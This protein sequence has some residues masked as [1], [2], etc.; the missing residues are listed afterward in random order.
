[1]QKK[2][3]KEY[4]GMAMSSI[5]SQALRAVLTVIIIAIGIMALV[6][7]LTSL[8]AL[9][10][11]ISGQFTQLGA[12]TF[13]IQNRGPNVTINKKG[14]RGKTF[15]YIQ[16]NEAV[17]FVERFKYEDAKVSLSYIAT[18]MAELKVG[19]EKTNPNVQI[20]ASD[21]NYLTTGG[22]ILKEGRNFS[23]SEI[24]L[25]SPVM[26]IGSDLTYLFGKENPLNKVITARGLR[27]RVIGILAS[28]GNAVGFGGDKVGLIPYTNARYAFSSPK[29][30]YSINVM[31]KDGFAMDAAI[32]EATAVMRNVRK[33]S[34][35]Q[36]TNFNITKSDNIAESL[37][38][39]LRYVTIA[40]AA[41]GFITL[42]GAA[43]ALMNIMLVSVTE[44]TRE[45][46]IRKAVGATRMA[47]LFQ[48]LIEAIIISQLGGLTGSVLGIAIGNVVSMVVGGTFFIPWDWLGLATVV[49]LAVGVLSGLYP[50]IRAAYLDPI[51]ALRHE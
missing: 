40:A 20:W 16:F 34:P 36:G 46:G 12:N 41:I 5:R 44:R 15:P 47:I 10:Q 2:L 14:E 50:A 13:T 4:I 38:D 45:I 9:K 19:S 49:C 33:L 27:Y 32:G 31:A 42:L 35:K 25:G 7:I 6:G 23:K 11:S 3:W 29:R 8:D 48:F 18:G 51:E 26:I 17:R 39:N 43:I 28:K 37:L 22:Y 1:M 30:S 24:E 21:P